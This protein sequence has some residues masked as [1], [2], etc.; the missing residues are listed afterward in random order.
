MRPHDHF[1][2][3]HYAARDAAGPLPFFNPTRRTF[4][5]P[6]PAAKAAARLGAAAPGVGQE[7][8]P[9]PGP[10]PAPPTGAYPIWRSRDNRKGR[11]ALLVAPEHVKP[12]A[13][14]PAALRA[15]ENLA[16]CREGI[17]KMFVRYPVWDV[18]YDVAVV[19]TLGSAVWVINGFFSWL[20]VSAPW[21]EF[22]GE[23]G[24]GSGATALVGATIFEI[25]SVLLMLEAVNE[26]RADCFGWALEEAWEDR[27]RGGG[28]GGWVAH[29]VRAECRHHHH[30]C[31][32]SLLGRVRPAPGV[33]GA[34]DGGEG[35]D[36]AGPKDG[37]DGRGEEDPRTGRRW[38][39][40]PSW[41]E[42]RTHYLRE[43]GFLACL[44]QMIGATVFWI[45]GFTALPPILNSLSKPAEYGVF[46]LPQVVGG[47]GFIVSSFLFMI[48][49]QEKWYLPAP[50]TL[51]WH[52]G[53]WNLVGAI[54]F[55]LCGAL[56]FAS[57]QP[58][59]EYALTLSTFVGSWAFL[60][61]SVIQWFESLDKYP[62]SV[63]E[64]P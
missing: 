23:T 14:E 49:V 20:P 3:R 31:R 47:T 59:M 19:F 11:H 52:I 1:I 56:G 4:T 24:T 18:S 13:G 17:W 30:G 44:S 29:P 40:M 25:G 60:I 38:L 32:R 27:R 53:L 62:V 63:K 34:A 57:G 43:I 41:Y 55:T 7:P 54:G 48:E 15:T 26:N 33:D 28:G 6:T 58:G 21:T 50:R 5:L 22:A 64:N 12:H 51:G 36:V 16:G 39:W 46:W 35:G 42:L 9:E 61:G 2:G 8:G 45:S 10:E 37:V